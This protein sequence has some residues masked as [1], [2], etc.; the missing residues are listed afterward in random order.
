MIINS[1][2]IRNRL[3]AL[4]RP[5]PLR[6]SSQRSPRSP[7]RIGDAS[8]EVYREKKRTGEGGTEERGLHGKEETREMKK[9]NG[10]GRKGVNP[11]RN[12]KSVPAV[13]YTLYIYVIL[14][15]DNGIGHI[16]CISTTETSLCVLNVGQ[17]QTIIGVLRLTSW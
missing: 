14:D 12:P 7:S 1:E 6:G 2:C 4:L 15:N 17:I 8:G 10:R 9:N 11:V 13:S 16:A 3:S 5:D